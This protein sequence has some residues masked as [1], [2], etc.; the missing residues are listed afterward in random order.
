MI[1]KYITYCLFFISSC[2]YLYS[3][4]VK[5]GLGSCLDQDYPQPI[6]EKIEEESLNYFI[7]LG[8][9][10]YGDTPSGSLRKMKS[11]YD[12]QKKNLT[13]FFK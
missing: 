12:K 1:K 9:N 5:I 6:W 3:D 2:N 13:K 8:D 4:S 7:F 10:V 11:A